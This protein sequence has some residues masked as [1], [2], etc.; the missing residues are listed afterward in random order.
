LTFFRFLG[1]AN[2]MIMQ[3]FSF[4]IILFFS[5]SVFAQTTRDQTGFSNIKEPT[6][7]KSPKVYGGYSAGCIAGAKFLPIEGEGYTVMRLNR[8]RNWGH[9]ELINYLQSLG[10]KVKDNTQWAGIRVGDMSQPRGGPLPSGHISHQSGLDVDIWLDPAPMQPFTLEER[11]TIAANSHVRPDMTLRESWSNSHEKMIQLAA[12]D[13]RV[14]RIFINAALKKKLCEKH[15]GQ[16]WL[17]KVRPW[18]GHDD[19]I[20]VR[21]NCPYGDKTCKNQ[22]SPPSSDGCSEKELA[23]WFTPEGIVPKNADKETI[24]TLNSLPK[25]CTHVIND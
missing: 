1:I 21:L 7:T 5:Q 2:I 9:P 4:I 23:W 22:P 14:S 15:K 11:E 18:F 17:S 19:H 8:N 3:I 13:S 20:H 16:K 25:A 6:E 12:D 24:F 10:K